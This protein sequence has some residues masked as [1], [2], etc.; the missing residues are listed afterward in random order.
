MHLLCEDQGV[1]VVGRKDV[2][3]FG[4]VKYG[5]MK[6]GVKRNLVNFAK[7]S[8]SDSSAKHVP[9][10]MTLECGKRSLLTLTEVSYRS[11]LRSK[12]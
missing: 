11:L 4:V 10:P 2:E 6:K 1:N 9:A 7:K 3:E 12:M 8:G 5:K